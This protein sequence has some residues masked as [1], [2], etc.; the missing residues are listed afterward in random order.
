MRTPARLISGWCVVKP[1][2]KMAIPAAVSAVPVARATQPLVVLGEPAEYEHE[3]A[4]S[5]IP[6][7]SRRL[8]G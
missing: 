2:R 8:R 4:A 5:V 7:C 3:H 6:E 1:A